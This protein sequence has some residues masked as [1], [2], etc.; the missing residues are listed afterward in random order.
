MSETALIR[1]FTNRSSRRR[2][3]RNRENRLAEFTEAQR[4]T[5]QLAYCCYGNSKPSRGGWTEER[6]ERKYGKVTAGIAE[7]AQ[8]SHIGL[9]S[10]SAG[11]IGVEGAC[12]V[13]LRVLK[14]SPEME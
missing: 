6:D 14:K 8:K 7:G 11:M 4:S 5:S 1:M 13:K 9:W 3:I 2:R 10:T 12:R